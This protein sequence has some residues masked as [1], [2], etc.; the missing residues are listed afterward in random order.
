MKIMLKYYYYY[1]FK[2]PFQW[3]LE[4]INNGSA[5]RSLLIIHPPI[6]PSLYPRQDVLI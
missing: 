6:Q 1:Y 5:N 4:I 3:N 2:E